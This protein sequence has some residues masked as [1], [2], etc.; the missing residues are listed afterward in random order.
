MSLFFALWLA[1]AVDEAGPATPASLSAAEL[2]TIAALAERTAELER[3]ATEL[4]SLTDEARRAV[5]AGGDQGEE[6]E[7]MQRLM[8]EIN[9]KNAALQADVHALE[10]RIHTSVNDPAWPLEP[11]DP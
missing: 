6:V 7:K 3:L 10:T 8:A 1:C 5:E 11:L 2:E 4:E 9:E